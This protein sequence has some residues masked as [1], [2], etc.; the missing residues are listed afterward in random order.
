[1]PGAGLDREDAFILQVFGNL[2]VEFEFVRRG[3]EI[4]GQ[5]VAAGEFDAADFLYLPAQG[6]FAD[7]A[8]AFPQVLE[9]G[10]FELGAAIA[11]LESIEAAE[12]VRVDD[13]DQPE[14]L[15]K[16]VL[17]RRRRKQQLGTS[18]E[19]GVETAC[20]PG[21]FTLVEVAQLVG[22]VENNQIPG[23]RRQFVLLARGKFV[24][25]DHH[26]WFAESGFHQKGIACSIG[27]SFLEV[28]SFQDF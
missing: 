28:S 3:A 1:M 16:V 13:G 24:G 12:E 9:F 23:N 5:R 2:L 19:G 20:D 4:L 21:A 26:G 7:G 14:Q 18:L 10:V 15:L 27:L 17:Q 22:F 25:A 8:Q 11:C 6:A